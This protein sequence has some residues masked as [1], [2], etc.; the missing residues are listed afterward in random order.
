MEAARA[1]APPLLFL[2]DS[3]S[4]CFEWLVYDGLVPQQVAGVCSVSQAN[5]Y[6]LTMP[7]RTVPTLRRFREALDAF[8][9]HSVTVLHIGEVDCRAIYWNLREHMALERAG[10]VDAVARNF[11]RL[12][13]EVTARTPRVVVTAPIRP[14]YRIRPEDEPG[15]ARVDAEDIL[16]LTDAINQRLGNAAADRGLPFVSVNEVMAAFGS[17]LDNPYY[18]AIPDSPKITHH[19]HAP[20]VAGFWAR[21]LAPHLT[22][23]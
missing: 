20:K 17:G 14:S 23:G 13:D 18:R 1:E 5:I 8:P 7:S 16:A 12:L 22:G 4:R 19:C 3:H 15:P 6:G 10:F 9:A 2:S 11:D 21:A